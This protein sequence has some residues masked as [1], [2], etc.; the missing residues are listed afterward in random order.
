MSLYPY[1][2]SPPRLFLILYGSGEKLKKLIIKAVLVVAVASSFVYSATPAWAVK[3]NLSPSSITLAEAQSAVVTVTLDE[4]I[5]C[6]DMDV[7]C[8]VD[9]ALS[10]NGSNRISLSATSISIAYQNWAVPV[11]FTVT[12]ISDQSLNTD[13]IEEVTADITSNSEYYDG[14]SSSREITVTDVDSDTIPTATYASGN[15]QISA[16]PGEQVTIGGSDFKPNTTVTATMF[17]T[18]TVLGTFTTNSSGS[19]TGS[20]TIPSSASI[21]TH[22]IVLSGTNYAGSNASVTLSLEVIGLA[23]TGSANIAYLAMVASLLVMAG[24]GLLFLTTRFR[25]RSLL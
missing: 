11:Q 17:S 15:T 23:D 24:F 7:T 9:I 1:I 22:T 21:G 3:M 16:K 20:V 10:V 2:Y 13:S 6:P 4:P 5:I 25:P 18:P 12:N 14:F 19:F 8:K